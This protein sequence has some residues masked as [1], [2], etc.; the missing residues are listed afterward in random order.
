[1]HCQSGSAIKVF[2]FIGLNCSWMQEF[3]VCAVPIFL[4]Q[5]PRLLELL[6]GPSEWS[7]PKLDHLKIT[8][9]KR[10]NE[11]SSRTFLFHAHALPNMQLSATNHLGR[12][13]ERNKWSESIP[14]F[15]TFVRRLLSRRILHWLM[16]RTPTRGCQE[17]GLRVWGRQGI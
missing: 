12:S 9:H 14:G 6:E 16:W 15:R 10:A 8:I 3:E 11:D 4:L 17:D 2:N 1:M 7:R 13:T 5:L